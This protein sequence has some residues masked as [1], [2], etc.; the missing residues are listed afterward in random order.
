MQMTV[1]WIRG[2]NVH[3]LKKK[4]KK[5][6]EGRPSKRFYITGRGPLL[7]ISF[8][9]ETIVFKSVKNHKI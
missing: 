3:C 5:N 2:K 9:D 6:V 1:F 8:M 4:V 7:G